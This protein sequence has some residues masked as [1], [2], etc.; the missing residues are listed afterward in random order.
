MKK[1]TII[2]L[3]SILLC[4][5][6]PLSAE[7]QTTITGM[8]GYTTVNNPAGSGVYNIRSQKPLNNGDGIL[9]RFTAFHLEPGDTANLFLGNALG[10]A[11]TSINVIHSVAGLPTTINGTLK[12][13]VGQTEAASI[14][15]N[16]I[17]INPNGFIVGS[18]GI[19]NAGSILLST[20]SRTNA[21]LNGSGLINLNSTAQDAQLNA[22]IIDINGLY[23]F[24]SITGAVKID[25]VLNT[26]MTT[27]GNTAKQGVNIFANN[28][29]ISNSGHIITGSEQVVNLFTGKNINYTMNTNQV[30]AQLAL[31]TS[32][33]INIAG[34]IKSPDNKVQIWSNSLDL[35]NN[36]VNITGIIDA[37]SLGHNV[38]G[39]VVLRSGISDSTSGEIKLN[40]GKIDSSGNLYINTS[41]S[42]NINGSGSTLK[43]NTLLSITG[44]GM[45]LNGTYES[46]DGNININNPGNNPLLVDANLT[47]HAGSINIMSDGS[48]VMDYSE[49]LL[50][51]GSIPVTDQKTTA[52]GNVSIFSSNFTSYGNIRS[53]NASVIIESMSDA[54]FTGHC[55]IDA[56][57]IIYVLANTVLV[58]QPFNSRNGNINLKTHT[59]NIF[60][61]VNGML[62]SLNGVINIFRLNESG[63]LNFTANGIISA[64]NVET[65]LNIG[66][67][68]SNTKNADPIV[69]DGSTFGVY[70]G[71][72]SQSTV[73]PKSPLYS[74]DLYVN[75]FAVN[76][77]GTTPQPVNPPVPP[78][79]KQNNNTAPD[80]NAD[81]GKKQNNN[82]DNFESE[83]DKDMALVSNEPKQD[84]LDYNIETNQNNNDN[85]IVNASALDD[86]KTKVYGGELPDEIINELSDKFWNI[87]SLAKVYPVDDGRG[88]DRNNSFEFDFKD[89]YPLFKDAL[90]GTDI[91]WL[92]FFSREDDT[93]S[94]DTRSWDE[95]SKEL[96]DYLV[97][98]EKLDAWE[99]E[100]KAFN[101]YFDN[102]NEI[103]ELE[104]WIKK[105][106][107]EYAKMSENYNNSQNAK[108]AYEKANKEY[109]QGYWDWLSRL[110]T[111][112]KELNTLQI[113]FSEADINDNLTPEQEELIEKVSKEV[114]ELR[115]Q[116]N[117]KD[118]EVDKLRK[119][120]EDIDAPSSDELNLLEHILSAKKTKLK[121]LKNQ[122]D[123][124]YKEYFKALDRYKQAEKNYQEY[125]QQQEIAVN[126]GGNIS[127]NGE[128]Q[129][130]DL[131]PI[132][133]DANG[134]PLWGS[135]YYVQGGGE[136]QSLNPRAKLNMRGR[137][138]AN[139]EATTST[140]S[141]LEVIKTDTPGQQ[142]NIY[143]Y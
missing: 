30:S 91:N 35:V 92:T 124:Y 77:I 11:H 48:T 85:N 15:G 133:Y 26:S 62:S 29:D 47:S 6:I 37:S 54:A 7:G 21:T 125:V 119:A 55:G 31:D 32:G 138:P 76:I 8:P 58:N 86:W 97:N 113:L 1:T 9:N 67:A 137:T 42:V 103:S 81:T 95:H 140:G 105:T 127:V 84:P 94:F 130:L 22:G 5:I 102:I 135:K 132:K 118:Q 114:N 82:N 139:P 98:K 43:A 100:K 69:L 33:G 126:K 2:K 75:N 101:D 87:M 36:T 110:I 38:V 64:E 50:P 96:K 61:G 60:L 115:E 57:D 89:T 80:H 20:S 27:A 142:T 78:K 71:S 12:Q 34:V 49:S 136:I 66:N 109:L 10:I 53:Q 17:F 13:F 108:E 111:K 90:E 3:L 14:G 19:I 45:Y 112:E 83:F 65:G 70:S 117:K 40:N 106:E 134:Q 129:T 44:D 41:N 56:L 143:S 121:D 68:T 52:S 141:V 93:Y 18:Q 131:S 128:T 73:V 123:Y 16:L 99:G 46:R 23:R 74:H 63:Q 25:G 28:I 51:A 79:P 4:L 59:G 39:E 116:D 122:T 72:Y 24:N 104:E 107:P 88:D 120:Y